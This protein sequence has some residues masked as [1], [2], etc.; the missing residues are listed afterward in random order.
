[1]AGFFQITDYGAMREF[2]DYFASGWES[3][4]KLAGRI[5]VMQTTPSKLVD[6]QIPSVDQIIGK[7]SEISDSEAK[8]ATGN[9]VRPVEQHVPY[10]II[11]PV[12]QV[13]YAPALPIP[14]K[15]RGQNSFTEQES[16]I[17]VFP[18]NAERAARPEKAIPF[19][20]R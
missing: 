18:Q 10:T 9:G 12:L 3:Q 20:L 8:L 19:L 7:A 17:A 11:E 2:C 5:G 16:I 13:R 4:R 15:A 6:R 1:V 14:P